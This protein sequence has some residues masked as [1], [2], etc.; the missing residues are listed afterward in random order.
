MNMNYFATLEDD[1]DFLTGPLEDSCNNYALDYDYLTGVGRADVVSGESYVIS[2]ETPYVSYET[3]YAVT[4]A[5]FLPVARVPTNATR[6]DDVGLR[7]LTSGNEPSTQFNGTNI[8]RLPSRRSR[9]PPPVNYS[10]VQDPVHSPAPPN[11]SLQPHILPLRDCG[12]HAAQVAAGVAQPQQFSA[13]THPTSVNDQVN[14]RKAWPWDR[15]RSSVFSRTD[16][17]VIILPPIQS[18]PAPAAEV[19]VHH[20]LINSEI[21]GHTL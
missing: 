1:H 10:A 14:L 7:Y 17:D 16:N 9:A 12:T 11:T 2:F 8:T 18:D 5:Q 6:S 4:N 15:R 19:G 3:A 20:H 13:H 21:N